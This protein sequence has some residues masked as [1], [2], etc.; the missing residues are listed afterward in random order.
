MSIDEI[1][2]KCRESISA[3]VGITL[4]IQG[5]VMLCGKSG[6]RGE[7]ICSSNSGNVVR[8]DPARVLK[9]VEKLERR[10]NAINS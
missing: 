6:P 8:F 1:K 5:G 4:V 7:L 2:E 3:G 9:F 10:L